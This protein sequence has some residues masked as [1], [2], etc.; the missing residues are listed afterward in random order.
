MSRD[1]GG[2]AFP[3]GLYEP[4]NAGSNDRKPWN[5]GM[6]LRDYFAGLAMQALI[7]KPQCTYNE[8]FA[9]AYDAADKMLAERAK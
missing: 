5:D 2:P 7:S 1:T 8:I 3:G 4:R 6:T 9:T